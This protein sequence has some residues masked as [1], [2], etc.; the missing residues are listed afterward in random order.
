MGLELSIEPGGARLPQRDSPQPFA[1]TDSMR[2][3][4]KTD[5]LN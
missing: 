1:F 3:H 2:K 4:I 5:V